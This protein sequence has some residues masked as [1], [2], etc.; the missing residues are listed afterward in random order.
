MFQ[1][2]N[3]VAHKEGNKQE[4]STHSIGQIYKKISEELETPFCQ[5]LSANG[6]CPLSL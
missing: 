6:R 2:Y 1:K 3:L 4:K 5:R